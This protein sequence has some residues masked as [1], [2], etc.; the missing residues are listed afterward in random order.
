MEL[1]QLLEK[2]INGGLNTQEIHRLQD[3][4]AHLS[5]EELNTNLFEVWQSYSYTGSRNQTAF[6]TIQTNLKKILYIRK[7]VPW[8]QYLYR[9]AVILLFPILGYTVYQITR[10]TTI[11]NLAQSQNTILTDKGEKSSII[12]SD[13]TQ[14]TLAPNSR[15]TYPATFGKSQRAVSLVG[16]AYFQVTTNPDAPFLVDAGAVN[17][18]VLG[19][20]FNLNA[21]KTNSF[22]ECSL[23]EGMVKVCWQDKPNEAVVLSPNQKVRFDLTNELI[24]KS[25][26]DLYKETAWM[27]NIL[28]FQS[29]SIASI[30]QQIE[31]FYG[32]D[33]AITGILPDYLLTASYK[34]NDINQVLKNLQQHFSF[35]YQKVGDQL[36]IKF[37]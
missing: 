35:S 34:E 30:I 13:G 37:N 18:E 3:L 11:S 24:R 16:E 23:E 26:T 22:V 12:L 9:A 8:R 4:T 25:T 17:V 28:I 10:E 7:A 6:K 31:Q 14:V 19:T 33:I 5:D 29:D 32:V 36:H 27:H 2:L 15:L 21:Y 1:K 20:S